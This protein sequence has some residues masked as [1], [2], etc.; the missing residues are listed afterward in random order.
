[1]KRKIDIYSKSRTNGL[2]QNITNNQVQRVKYMSMGLNCVNILTQILRT[3]YD[4]QKSKCN[5][6]ILY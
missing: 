5:R 1:M 3:A 4:T 2:K 6:F